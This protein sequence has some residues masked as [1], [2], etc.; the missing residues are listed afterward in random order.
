MLFQQMKPVVLIT[1]DD[2]I[3]SPVLAEL[4]KQLSDAFQPIFAAPSTEMSWSSAMHVMKDVHVE[5]PNITGLTGFEA[6]SINC[7]PVDCVHIAIQNLGIKPAL[8]ISGI[9]YGIN[10]G[11]A[12]IN[13][14]GTV[15]AA[16]AAARLGF[17]S[18]AVS[19]FYP[20]E[21]RKKYRDVANLPREL[22]INETHLASEIIKALYKGHYFSTASC[23]NINIPYGCAGLSKIRVCKV[24]EESGLRLFEEK[25]KETAKE[26]KESGT[27]H[28]VAFSHRIDTP[29]FSKAPEDTDLGAVGKGLISITPLKPRFED[30]GLR[31]KLHSIFGKMK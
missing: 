23:L 14:S 30:D 7:S 9:N 11:S 2:G 12:R 22:Y 4:G 16:I 18:L 10:C 27:L 20:P 13:F 29:N 17:P 21:Y 8:V 6:Y 5:K 15:Q 28:T 31:A 1:N 25:D 19:I 24:Y 3:H 26:A